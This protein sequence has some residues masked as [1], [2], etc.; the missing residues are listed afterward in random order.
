MGCVDGVVSHLWHGSPQHRLYDKPL[1][2][3]RNF[4]PDCDLAVNPQTGLYEW[5]NAS[6][7]LRSW[8]EHYF[9]AR[10]EDG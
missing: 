2:V 10:Q 7:E 5:S 3:L 1:D 6:N 9:R 8:S 4:D